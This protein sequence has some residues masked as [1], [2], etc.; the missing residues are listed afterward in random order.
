MKLDSILWRLLW[1]CGVF[2][3]W[4]IPFLRD[5]VADLDSADIGE[6]DGWIREK[7]RGMYESA[8]AGKTPAD[9]AEDL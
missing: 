8:K 4:A 7:Y 5:L 6:D 2:R 3:A 1:S 9:R